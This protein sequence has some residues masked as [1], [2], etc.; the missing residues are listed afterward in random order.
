MASAAA[1]VVVGDA[2]AVGGTAAI[3]RRNVVGLCASR[4]TNHGGGG[5][6]RAF[7][8]PKFWHGVMSARILPQ[9]Y[10]PS[11]VSN[12]WTPPPAFQTNTS[13]PSKGNVPRRAQWLHPP[14]TTPIRS[15]KTLRGGIAFCFTFHGGGHGRRHRRYLGGAAGASVQLHRTPTPR[16]VRLSLT[17]LCTT[18]ILNNMVEQPCFVY[19]RFC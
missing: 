11:E 15:R 14:V 19:L 6:V 16:R 17:V 18:K 3:S 5:G 10:Q 9:R 4:T 12:P 2:A 13:W 7:G 8:A 1:V